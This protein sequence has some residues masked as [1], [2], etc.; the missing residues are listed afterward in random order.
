MW[1][2]AHVAADEVVVDPKTIAA[3][4]PEQM[5]RTALRV[6]PAA[7][8]RWSDDW[9]IYTLWRCNRDEAEPA[10]AAIEWRGEG[11]L[12]TR[13][14]G[15]VQIEPLAHAAVVL[16]DAFADGASIAAAVGAALHADADTDIAGV[17]RQLLDA[18]AFCALVPAQP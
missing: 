18:G 6:H 13:P 5:E 8:W 14:V 15:P 12:V 1:T 10:V 16:L 11:V 17:I 2:E 3:L 9:P 4:T 7:R